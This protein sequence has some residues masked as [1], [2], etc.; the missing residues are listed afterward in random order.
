MNI[1]TRTGDRGQTGLV[2]GD[3]V[4]K[5]HPRVEAYGDVDELNCAI[6]AARAACGISHAMLR[7]LLA[8]TQ[9]ECFEIGALLATPAHKLA[10]SNSGD[11]DFLNGASQRLENEIDAWGKEL[12]PLKTFVLPG[13]TPTGAALHLARA[14]CRRAERRTIHLAAHEP[15]PAGLAIYLNRL[16]DWLFTAAR[17]ANMK[18]GHEETSWTGR[19]PK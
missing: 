12:K 11:A 10:I 2:G 6:G 5:N 1:Y 4:A 8:R 3:R 17:W 14:V 15:L 9:S 7:E 16:S 18:S 13:G 19:Q